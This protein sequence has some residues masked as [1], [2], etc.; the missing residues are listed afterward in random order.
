[1]GF[2]VYR[3][4]KKNENEIKEKERILKYSIKRIDELQ[5]RDVLNHRTP[6]LKKTDSI[7]DAI[8]L[9]DTNN[10][11]LIP[12][13]EKNKIYGVLTKK[14]IVM[15]LKDYSY[16]SLEKTKIDQ[17]LEEDYASCKI[18]LSLKE[19]LEKMSEEKT[20]SIIVKSERDFY[21]TI[22]YFDIISIFSKADF[23][24]DNPP[25]LRESMN[26][27]FNI[28]NLHKNLDELKKNLEKKNEQYS[29]V[30]EKGRVISI[31]TLKDMINA[32]HK[33]LDFKKTKIENIMAHTLV[34]M[35]PGTSFYEAFRIM[36]DR[37]FNQIPVIEEDK[38]IGIVG[39]GDVA[40]YYY[41]FITNLR[42]RKK[43]LLKKQ[44]R[45]V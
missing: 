22:D 36:I 42:K 13:V 7:L 41:D 5:A 1:V 15:G 25:F 40:T 26:K 19:I 9:F 18:D 24:F 2:A 12:V 4:F 20:E 39:I 3:A 23:I 11:N 30:S 27:K 31:V 43:Y 35:E 32:I 45:Y 10:I 38:I 6:Q 33:N 17:V 29:L 44:G 37:K 28:I 8:E 14:E 21:G 34:S 16:S